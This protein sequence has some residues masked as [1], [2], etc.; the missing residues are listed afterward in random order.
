MN[1]NIKKY[2]VALMLVIGLLVL[3]TI[4][5]V[6]WI[7]LDGAQISVPLADVNKIRERKETVEKLRVDRNSPAFASLIDKL[8]EMEHF[9]VEIEEV[10]LGRDNPFSSLG[11]VQTDE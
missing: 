6:L 3:A 5:F 7:D 2:G 11:E 9:A 8:E 1:E 10:S 4:Y